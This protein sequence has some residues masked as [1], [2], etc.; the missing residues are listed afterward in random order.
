MYYKVFL[1]GDISVFNKKMVLTENS[2]YNVDSGDTPELKEGFAVCSKLT[3]ALILL[4]NYHGD[5]IRSVKVCDLIEQSSNIL[6]FKKITI[7]SKIT[8][9][10]AIE[11]IRTEKGITGDDLSL[12]NTNENKVAILSGSKNVFSNRGLKSVIVCNEKSLAAINSTCY[13]SAI[14][15]STDSLAYSNALGSN[16]IC[17]NYDTLAV[18]SSRCSFAKVCKEESIAIA[19]NNGYVSGVMG[20]WL[21]LV[22]RSDIYD[23][24]TKCCPIKEIKSVKVDGINIKENTYYTLKEGK[25]VEFKKC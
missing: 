22:E 7:G 11:N 16:A 4:Y 5:Y 24:N 20:A 1:K 14:T 23:Y 9:M 12:V 25:I 19:T 21:V 10:E 6:Y 8:P 15:T 3:D 18:V 13:S 2:T 17:Y